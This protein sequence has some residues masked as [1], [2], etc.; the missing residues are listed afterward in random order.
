MTQHGLKIAFVD[1][2]ISTCI[3][4]FKHLPVGNIPVLQE[5][6]IRFQTQYRVLQT[7][8]S[9][10]GSPYRIAPENSLAP[11]K[12]RVNSLDK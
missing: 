9:R 7:L 11:Y 10:D 3:D 12:S 1:F 2:L 8:T 5:I 4:F 6:L